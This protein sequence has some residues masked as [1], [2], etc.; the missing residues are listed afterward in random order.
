MESSLAEVERN[1]DVVLP[2]RGRTAASFA[3]GSARLA[4]DSA[5]KDK[6]VGREDVEYFRRRIFVRCIERES[7]DS[8]DLKCKL[9]ERRILF[10]P[11]R[12]RAP[13]CECPLRQCGGLSAAAADD[14][15]I[16][17]FE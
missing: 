12:E 4:E 15:H 3:R 10:E 8:G 14:D 9:L 6:D 1:F 2:V 11:P 5:T 17:P 7:L 16:F 13:R